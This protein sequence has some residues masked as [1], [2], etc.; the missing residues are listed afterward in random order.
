MLGA[1]CGSIRRCVEDLWGAC[2]G[3]PQCVHEIWHERR[4]GGL[5]TEVQMAL[6]QAIADELART[7]A[8]RSPA[9][10]EPEQAAPA[11]GE[12]GDARDNF[13]AD[14]GACMPLVHSRRELVLPRTYAY[15]STAAPGRAAHFPLH[16][17]QK[18]RVKVVR[19]LL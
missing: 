16:A 19:A 9:P 4:R 8:G 1:L 11:Q 2:E 14:A 3:G 5:V 17:C 13:T 12:P 18:V 10:K 15:C 6:G 7:Q